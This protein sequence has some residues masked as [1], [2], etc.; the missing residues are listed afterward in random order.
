V[1]AREKKAADLDFSKLFVSRPAEGRIFFNGRRAVILDVDALG[2]LRQLLID[3]IGEELARGVLTRFGYAHGYEDARVLGE[4]FSWATERDWLAAGPCLHI[5]EGIVHVTTEKIEFDRESGHFHMQGIWLN[6]YE[7]EG[8]LKLRSQSDHPVCW[9]LTGYAS[10]YASRFFGRNLLAIETECL[11]RGD[12]RCRF[13]IRPLAAWGLEAEPYLK[14]MKAVD[15]VNQLQH[16][17]LVSARFRDMALIGADWVWETDSEGRYTYCSGQVANVLGYEP[18]EV[19]GRTLFDFMPTAESARIRRIFCESVSLRQP[20]VDLEYDAL[21]RDGRQVVQVVSGMP[22]VD[23]ESNKL[24]FRGVARDITERK[25]AEAALKESR[26]RFRNLVETTSDWVWEIDEEGVYTYSSPQVREILGYDAEEVLGKRP[27]DLMAP[28]ETQRVAGV[29]RE[30]VVSQKPFT[31]LENVNLHKNG[32]RVLLETSGVPF[33]DGTGR[34]RGYRGIDRDITAR[35]QAEA[36]I[37]F[38]AYHDLLTGLPNRDQL[39]FLFQ[40]KLAE[41]SRHDR[42]LAVVHLDLDRF[43]AINDSM[44]HAIGDK[45]IVAAAERLKSFLTERDALARIGSDEFILLVGVKRSEDAGLL[46]RKLVDAMRQIYRLNGEDIHVTASIGISMYPEDSTNAEILLRNADVAVSHVKERGRNN[47]QFFN[48]SL[49]VR[50]VER[51]LLESSLRHTIERDELVLHYQPLV[52]IRTGKVVCLEA[53]VRW[54]HADLGMLNP[55]DFIPVAEEIGFIT[56]IDEWVLR[57]ACAQ[58]RKW[59]E[60]G[61]PPLCVTVNLSTQQFQQ[62]ALVEMV[63]AI[64]RETDLEARYLGI[65]VTES[66][67]MRD[68]DLAIPSLNG[69][70]KLGVSISIDDFGTGYSS[71]NYLKRFPVQTLKIDQ[72]FIRDL[73]TDLDDQAIVRAVIAMGHS[74]NLKV[75]A[76]GVETAEQHS[77]L[78]A[79]DCDEIQGFLFSRPLPAEKLDEFLSG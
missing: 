26:E 60:M 79:N 43:K 65:E 4:S 69:L 20:I 21:A 15:V 73:T 33:F 3:T 72:T 30:I 17:Q 9:T 18:G 41:A 11:G 5:L 32:S 24:M 1:C 10:G 63:A 22:V 56:A 46:A 2:A 75:V 58:N 68:I 55:V 7:A 28:E 45:V 44:G 36:T 70:K 49:N 19:V 13:E 29:F 31:L 42:K 37:E 57:A 62:P 76:E 48:S 39:M 52:S 35:K 74:L 6:S 78:L 23:K 16:L 77:F 50:T 54:R 66:T 64:L 14:A 40:L 27:F 8:H 67:A 12:G 71:L 34:F 47:F 51:L 61:Y 25:Q 59:Q 38:Q 53:L